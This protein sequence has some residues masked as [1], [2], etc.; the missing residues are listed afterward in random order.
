MITTAIGAGGAGFDS[1]WDDPWGDNVRQELFDAGYGDPEV[2]KVRDALTNASFPSKT[3]LTRYV[4]SHDEAD[5][6]RLAVAIDS[7]D[8]YS[9]WA[10][11]R[12]KL[13]QGLTLLVPGIPMFLQGGEWLENIPFGSGVANRIDWSKAVSRAPLTQFFHDAIAVRKGNCAFRSNAGYEV[14]HLSEGANVLAFHRWCNNGNDIVVIANFGN[15]DYYN[16]QIGFPQNGIWYELL[17]S[18]AA[19]YLGNNLGNGGAVTTSGGAYDGMPYSAFV[20]IPQMGLLV[21]RYNDPPGPAVRRGDL[22]CDG[23]VGFGD[24][25][26]FVMVLTN[27]TGWQQTYPGCPLANADINADGSVNFGDI[28][29]FVTLLTTP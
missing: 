12:S 1:Q 27:L 28:N 14:H 26:P 8:S 7:S 5:D 2:W 10:K 25:N 18:Q 19:A 23:S 17:N 11:G 15:N 6:A 16:Y 4:E 29:P 9:V 22:N 3:N 21:L 20:T 13:A 24:I